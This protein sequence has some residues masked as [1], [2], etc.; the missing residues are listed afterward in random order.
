M[1]WE[2]SFDVDHAVDCATKVFSQ[3]GYGGA[4]LNELISATGVNRGSLYNAFHGKRELFV[5]ALSRYDQGTRRSR[6]DAIEHFTDPRQAII[7]FFAD[8]VRQI[9][10]DEDHTG[11]LMVNTALELPSHDGEIRTIVS[12]SFADMET[13]FRRLIVAGQQKGQISREADPTHRAKALVGLVV[14]MRVL[15]RGAVDTSC[16]RAIAAQAT[17]L[18]DE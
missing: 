15:A 9:E 8:V 16:I 7:G 5:K 13:F 17:R 2:K 10:I 11:C 12:E 18:I 3:K 4:S 6:M 14:G 1:P